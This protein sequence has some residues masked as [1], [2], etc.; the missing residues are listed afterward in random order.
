[1]KK[2]LL[3][4]F[5]LSSITV[6]ASQYK[7][8]VYYV[9]ASKGTWGWKPFTQITVKNGK[10]TEV[11]TDRINS[12]G[13]LASKDESYNSSMLKKNKTNPKDYS[14]KLPKNYYK[15]N[16]NIDKIDGIAG[17]TDTVNEFKVMM[18]FLIDKAEKGQPGKYE[19][20]KKLLN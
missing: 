17:A 10:I 2:L 7:D 19:I 14:D 20:D 3:L 1:M 18:K 8:G 12:K 4:F 15:A 6:L 13:E 11:I 5:I 16:G 9:V